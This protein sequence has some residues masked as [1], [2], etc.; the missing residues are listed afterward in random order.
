MAAKVDAPMM[1][2]IL[3]GIRFVR[4]NRVIVSLLILSFVPILLVMPY[5]MLMPE[6]AR[7]VFEAG[8]TGLGVLMSATGIGALAGSMTTA[9]LGDY[10]RKGVLML[11]TGSLFGCFLVPFAL[12]DG[13]LPASVCLLFVGA[14]SSV[15]MSLNNSLLMSNTPD[16]LMGRVMSVFMMTFGLMPLGTLLYGFLAEVIGAPLTVAGGGFLLIGFLSV[17]SVSQPFIRRLE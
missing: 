10:K 4:G 14:G 15:Y 12:S 11:A 9:A 2:E 3:D 13:L 17:L 7:N 16:D 8:E 5:Q 1:G 6:F